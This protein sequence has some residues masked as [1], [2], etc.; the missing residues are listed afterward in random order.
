MNLVCN[1]G[2]GPA[3]VSRQVFVS[4]KVCVAVFTYRSWE[5]QEMQIAAA[6]RLGL[7]S[8]VWSIL[9]QGK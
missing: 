1:R 7:F 5:R 4:Q 3:C 2:F 9:Q 8:G 6:R